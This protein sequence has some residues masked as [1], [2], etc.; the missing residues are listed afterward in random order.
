MY[1]E[2]CG[3]KLHDPNQKFCPNCGILLRL[4]K[5]IQLDI[6]VYL[7]THARKIW[8]WRAINTAVRKKFIVSRIVQDIR[9]E[10]YNGYD[11]L[12][13]DEDKEPSSFKNF[14]ENLNSKK[15]NK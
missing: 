11:I 1:C 7:D 3:V 4:K 10:Y 5:K 14:I 8:V 6:K 15:N 2:N 9:D 12:G 13:V